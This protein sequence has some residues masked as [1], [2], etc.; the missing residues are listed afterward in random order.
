MSDSGMILLGLAVIGLLILM[1]LSCTY[2]GWG[3][4]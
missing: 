2:L 4:W 1:G 3:C